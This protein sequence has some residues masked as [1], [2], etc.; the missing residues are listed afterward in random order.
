VRP[1]EKREPR[2]RKAEE[3]D[4]EGKDKVKEEVKKETIN[5][6]EE[7]EKKLPQVMP[8]YVKFTGVEEGTGYFPIRQHIDAT[9]GQVRKG[10]GGG[11]V[12]ASACLLCMPAKLSPVRV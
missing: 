4:G 12:L 3:V 7:V 5:V 10:G 6:E 8:R 2:K 1:F 11:I 9:Y